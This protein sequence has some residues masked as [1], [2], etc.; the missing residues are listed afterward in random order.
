MVYAQLGLYGY[1][2]YGFGQSVHLLR[3]ELGISR[4]LGSL[5][6]TALAGGAIIAGVTGDA[7]VRRFGRGP[8]LWAG[9]LGLCAGI[10]GYCVAGAL[11]LTLLAALVCGTSGSWIVNTANATLMEAHGVIGPA[12]L[13]EGNA[14][15]AA[16]GTLAPLVVGAAV[17]LG[18]GWRAGLLVTLALAFLAAMAFR[19]ERLPD[20]HPIDPD[21]HPDGAHSL[22]RA[23]WITWGILVCTISIE[24]CLSLWASDLL[25]SRDRLTAGT[26]TAAWSGLLVGVALSRLVGSRLAVRH[27]VDSVLMGALATLFAGFGLFWLTTV[28]WL[29]V[30]GLFV[31]GLGLGVQY[32]LTIGR[33][34]TAAVGRSDLAAARA[35][36]AAGLAVGGG[37][38]LLGALAD[39][40]GSHTAFLLVPALI[41]LAAAGLAVSRPRPSL[42]PL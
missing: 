24:F 10:V 42:Q 1:F 20:P 9:V 40:F 5:H 7:A 38:F 13:S 18:L 39:R 41:L 30:L 16:A 36:L 3:D 17:G 28:P 34:I 35:S 11:P 23:Y 19:G 2:L 15:A 12:A 8:M 14:I 25:A 6:G 21:D 29:A 37:P 4:T 26:A 27:S 33:A 32:P 22:P 31:A